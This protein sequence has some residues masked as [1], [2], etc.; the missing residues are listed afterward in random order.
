MQDLLNFTNANG[1]VI[2]LFDGK[3]TLSQAVAIVMTIA[4]VLFAIKV[5]K[6]TIRLVVCVCAV[7]ACLV[8]FN[9]ASPAQIRDAATQVAQA[10]V[11]S[12]QAIA[13]SSKSIRLEGKSIQ[14]IVGDKWVDVSDITSIVGGE[15][16]KATVVV[17]GES[18]VVE[19]TAVI[20]LI[21]SFT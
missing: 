13:D 3:M 1:E 11:A 8:H 10:G 6:K 4:V 18:Y 21:K 14:I 20:K 2:T 19:D 16:G 9:I 15:S 7:C 5:L 17:D 12:Y